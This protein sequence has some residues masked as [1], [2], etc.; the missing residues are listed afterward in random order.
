MSRPFSRFFH[1]GT[2]HSPQ[3]HTP[4]AELTVFIAPPVRKTPPFSEVLTDWNDVSPRHDGDRE[5]LFAKIRE[6]RVGGTFWATEAPQ[7]EE[8]RYIVAMPRSM[9]KAQEL[10]RR[11][12]DAEGAPSRWFISSTRRI[13][14]C[15]AISRRRAGTI[16]SALTIRM[17]FCA[18]ICR[19][20]L[21][22]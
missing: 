4:G 1:W 14:N 10:W 17:G 9:Q 18:E 22:R 6:A 15:F 19:Y 21:P 2:M 11:V 7:I 5:V 20:G 13:R 3:K 16:L 8:A 12:S